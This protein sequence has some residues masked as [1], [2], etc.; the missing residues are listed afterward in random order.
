M[1]KNTAL[2]YDMSEITEKLQE[3]RDA[4]SAQAE[5]MKKVLEELE[6]TRS[7]RDLVTE[8]LQK[9]TGKRDEILTER[10]K[11]IDMLKQNFRRAVD[12][13][14]KKALVKPDADEVAI[15]RIKELYKKCEEDLRKFSS[16]NEGQLVSSTTLNEIKK[17][18]EN[19]L[20]LTDAIM[21]VLS[22]V[23][24]G[25]RLN[26]RKVFPPSQNEVIAPEGTI[27]TMTKNIRNLEAIVTAEVKAQGAQPI[28]IV[29]MDQKVYG[30]FKPLIDV[31]DSAEKGQKAVYDAHKHLIA[32]MYDGADAI[33]FGYGGSGAGKTFTLIG[34]TAQTINADNKGLLMR[35]IDGIVED[36]KRDQIKCISIL[37]YEFVLAT[38]SGYPILKS[39]IDGSKKVTPG[40]NK[41]SSERIPVEYH[42]S[43][44]PLA[45][46]N[47]PIMGTKL[48]AYKGFLLWGECGD[49]LFNNM[50]I[51]DGLSLSPV[52]KLEDVP[53]LLISVISYIFSS[54]KRAT[55]ETQFNDA[56]SRSHAFAEISIHL[57]DGKVSRLVIGDL[58]GIETPPYSY[59]SDIL[60]DAKKV[61]ELAGSWAIIWSL[62][63]ITKMIDLYN[64]NTEDLT[65]ET[66][67]AQLQEGNDI[68]GNY[69]ITDNGNNSS[70]SD[71]HGKGIIV[72][73]NT[74]KSVQVRSLRS[75]H[76]SG[77][78]IIGVLLERYINTKQE[79]RKTSISLLTVVSIYEKILGVYIPPD[80]M[81]QLLEITIKKPKRQT[82]HS[83]PV[84]PRVV[85]PKQ[86]P[87]PKK[88]HELIVKGKPQQEVPAFIGEKMNGV[89]FDR[90]TGKFY[91]LNSIKRITEE[92]LSIAQSL[93]VLAP[94]V[95]GQHLTTF[96]D[97][98]LDFLQ[99]R[100][101]QG[102]IEMKGLNPLLFMY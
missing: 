1:R 95:G 38:S 100:A 12:P 26:N 97:A 52:E 69:M 48:D 61:D 94:T 36:T 27:E 77:R 80:D 37:G 11:T 6:K 3:L 7:E 86:E 99:G 22:L 101:T 41:E 34:P 24:I 59:T 35:L 88:V 8:E 63:F 20:N 76:F 54:Q 23:M 70:I 65:T 102:K 53:A 25:V 56:S 10:R 73:T 4:I 31:E 30:S 33:I 78:G 82:R 19:S 18:S 71:I 90:R 43:Y 57:H 39:L 44:Q 49:W 2:L 14:Y 84:R 81:R 85:V 21:D 13:L 32:K 28:G 45:K 60:N 9:L 92:T 98:F 68:N 15:R 51:G 67:E 58:A 79:K 42:S 75:T 50:P 29:K 40:T 83:E 91:A 96:K 55:A 5:F 17:F 62:R 47:L 74:A 46:S 89:Y 72:P 93:S 64:K 87:E 16:Y 66:V